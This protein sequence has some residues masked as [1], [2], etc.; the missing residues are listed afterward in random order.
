MFGPLK[1][2]ARN[3]LSP[4]SKIVRIEEINRL[5]A[6]IDALPE[7]QREAL[8]LVRY[9]GMSYQQAG[10][11][12]DLTLDATRM[13]VARAIVSLSKSMGASGA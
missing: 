12:L 10:D 2:L 6:A 9:E 7:N 1:E 4:A 11:K 3:T 5:E 8:L 13:L